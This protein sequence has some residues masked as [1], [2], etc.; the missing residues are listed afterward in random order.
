[1]NG[2]RLAT[3]E[4][5]A[6]ERNHVKQVPRR[7]YLR[8]PSQIDLMSNLDKESTGSESP[9]P[10]PLTPPPP[11]QPF[12]HSPGIANRGIPM[13]VKKS[14]KS[15]PTPFLK[16]NCNDTSPHKG[17]SNG[18]SIIQRPLTDSSESSSSS[19][20][21]G[22]KAGTAPGRRSKDNRSCGHDSTM[23]LKAKNTTSR[24]FGE[25]KSKDRLRSHVLEPPKR[26]ESP[27]KVPAPESRSPSIL[28][29]PISTL[30]GPKQ[31]P[32]PHQQGDA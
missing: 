16:Y 21:V 29:N 5:D 25:S 11:P 15:T 14:P 2:R 3:L 19:Q 28:R 18:R 10:S 20:R 17:Q 1:M 22:A 27:R 30:P 23:T 9:K 24:F 13:E 4:R 7:S 31:S 12:P 8:P 26:T 6:F 32:K